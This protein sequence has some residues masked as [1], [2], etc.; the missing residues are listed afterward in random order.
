[1]EA[2]V[3]PS[4]L[5]TLAFLFAAGTLSGVTIKNQ[6]I[7]FGINDFNHRLDT[8]RTTGGNPELMSDDNKQVIHKKDPSLCSVYVFVDGK[9]YKV[10]VTGRSLRAPFITN[11]NAIVSEWSLG[12]I[13]VRQTAAI[14]IGTTSGLPDS[15]KL[16]YEIR[17]IDSVSHEIGV[18][19]VMDTFIGANDNSPFLVPLNGVVM[20]ERK[21]TVVPDYFI[22][23]DSL[24]EPSVQFQA[25]LL[26]P[27]L[28]GPESVV[29]SA[30]EKLNNSGWDIPVDTTKPMR[31]P[32]TGLPDTGY[33]LFWGPI[34]F[35]DSTVRG[36]IKRISTMIGLVGPVLQTGE[37]VDAALIAPKN[38]KLGAFSVIA[39]AH[40]KD[41]FKSVKNAKIEV[42]LPPNCTVLSK[43]PSEYSIPQMDPDAIKFLYYYIDAETMPEGE[44]TVGI[45]IKGEANNSFTVTSARR[46]IKK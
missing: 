43:I 26:G 45:T 35:P 8:L 39:L 37:M 11:A 44:S 27:G 31:D 18:K 23:L 28:A 14:A 19:M 20:K 13:E 41:K 46:R 38:V 4:A 34:T 9:A 36:S 1:M 7:E 21:V 17:N 16:T 29:F 6:Y 5:W 42:S 30:P 32:A 33:A 22:G 10:G 24:L 2:S 25:T 3:K 12:K 15:I 40:N